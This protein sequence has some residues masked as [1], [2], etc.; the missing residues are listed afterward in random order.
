MIA[1]LQSAINAGRPYATNNRQGGAPTGVGLHHSSRAQIW[2][3]GAPARSYRVEIGGRAERTVDSGSSRIQNPQS[4]F[5]TMCVV[6][7][8]ALRVM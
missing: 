3:I 5:V 1:W 8:P 4:E 6:G 2:R 7:R